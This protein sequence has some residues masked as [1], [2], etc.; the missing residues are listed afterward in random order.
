MP[1]TAKKYVDNAIKYNDIKKKEKIIGVRTNKRI[2]TGVNRIQALICVLALVGLSTLSVYHQIEKNELGYKINQE[3]EALET[4]KKD[5]TLMEEKLFNIYNNIEI[6]EQSQRSL[7]MGKCEKY[8]TEY[9]SIP[10][11]DSVYRAKIEEKYDV[12]AKL[13]RTWTKLCEYIKQK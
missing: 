9:I 1:S 6:A 2:R 7:V 8:Q 10:T 11:E 5:N 3:K 4:L 13:K 12:I